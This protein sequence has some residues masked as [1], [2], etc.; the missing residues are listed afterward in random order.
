MKVKTLFS[1]ILC[2]IF[3]L[4]CN[5]SDNQRFQEAKLCYDNGDKEEAIRL[6]V[7]VNK[8]SPHY[9]EAQQMLK[10]SYRELVTSLMNEHRYDEATALIDTLSPGS[11][12]YKIS[13]LLLPCIQIDK[14]EHL[15]QN[16]ETKILSDS[17]FEPF[18]N[19]VRLLQ[20]MFDTISSDPE[21]LERKPVYGRTL[22]LAYVLESKYY[23]DKN[24]YED[25]LEMLNRANPE[26]VGYEK[27]NSAKYTIISAINVI[28]RRNAIQLI[29]TLTLNISAADYFDSSHNSDYRY[30]LL[31]ELNEFKKYW[32]TIYELKNAYH[33]DDEIMLLV[34][35]LENEVIRV[36]KREFPI[37]RKQYAKILSKNLWIEDTDV[38]CGGSRNTIISFIG[39]KYATRENVAD[40]QNT[41]SSYLKQFR[42]KK[43]IYYWCRGFDSTHSYNID[44]PDDGAPIL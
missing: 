13:R 34:T 38:Y 33:N 14:I 16:T 15:I 30:D 3:L 41:E 2:S 36:Q 19:N 5:Y 12:Y 9:T 11:C 21:L 44:S 20:Y 6:L 37:L 40:T 22:S 7:L 25:A 1:V 28:R 31:D 23:V 17:C 10:Q 39:Y 32:K 43:S 27:L 42:F 4:S 26:Y 18:D 35:K 29:N 8:K 24:R